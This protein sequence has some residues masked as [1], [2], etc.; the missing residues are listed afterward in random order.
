MGFRPGYAA[1]RAATPAGSG[2]AYLRTLR[3]TE[4][5]VGGVGGGALPQLVIHDVGKDLV[6]GDGVAVADHRELPA[7]PDHPGHELPEE[8]ERRICD[9]E[10]GFVAQRRHLGTAEVAVGPLARLLAGQA[11]LDSDGN[12]NPEQVEVLRTAATEKAREV[13][14]ELNRR[15][16]AGAVDQLVE[17]CQAALLEALRPGSEGWR[18]LLPGRRLIEEY[19]RASGLGD[20]GVFMSSLI[21]HLAARPDLIPGELTDVEA[22]IEAG[23]LFGAPAA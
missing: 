1:S 20:A 12:W 7:A 8:A 6:V 17:N 9:D 2:V 16:D 3:D 5:H 13:A 23:R 18:T 11:V 22:T 14:V 4:H 10:I 15:T 19:V 21:S